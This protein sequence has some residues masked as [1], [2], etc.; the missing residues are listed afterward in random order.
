M[1][2]FKLT[3]TFVNNIR[4][5]LLVCVMEMQRVR[6]ELVTEFLHF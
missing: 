6:C 3:V 4:P 5:N 2:S 1:E